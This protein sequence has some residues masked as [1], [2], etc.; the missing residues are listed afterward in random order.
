VHARF[1]PAIALASVA[2]IAVALAGCAAKT[3]ATAVVA[4]EAG[5]SSAAAS[6][7]VRA[8]TIEEKQDLI[9]SNFQIEV[10]VPFGTVVRGEAQGSNAWDYELIVDAPVAAVSMWYE[11]SYTGRE[12]QFVSQNVPQAGTLILTFVKNGAQ[13]RVTISPV[14]GGEARVQGILGIGAPV[15]QSE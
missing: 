7:K 1:T 6:A 4:P 8:M 15:L 14:S 3:A 10:P 2:L 12:W 5:I 11:R 9:A 13:T